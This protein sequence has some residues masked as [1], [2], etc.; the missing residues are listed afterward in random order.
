MWLARTATAEP[1]CTDQAKAEAACE[2][3]PA[4]DTMAQ[5]VYT[6]TDTNPAPAVPPDV[7]TVTETHSYSKIS[8]TRRRIVT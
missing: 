7:L 5:L 2:I 1:N 8:S 4:R 6:W 3:R